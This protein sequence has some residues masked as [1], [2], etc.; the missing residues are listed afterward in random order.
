MI[1][2]LELSKHTRVWSLREKS[3]PTELISG[4]ST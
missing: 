2:A 3:Q 4:I 1:A